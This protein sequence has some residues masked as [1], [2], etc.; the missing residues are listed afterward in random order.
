MQKCTQVASLYTKILAGVF[1]SSKYD[2]S[3]NG[4]VEAKGELKANVFGSKNSSYGHCQ[5]IHS[6]FWLEQ[7]ESHWLLF[8]LVQPLAFS[9]FW[10]RT[11][12]YSTIWLQSLPLL[13]NFQW[14]LQK[15]S[16]GLFFTFL[17]LQSCHIRSCCYLHGIISCGFFHQWKLEISLPHFH[18]TAC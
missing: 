10:A 11:L 6:L 14:G 7:K 13:A 16:N 3:C 12:S 5:I 18:C 2:A 15:T 9:N 4:S 1:G 17:D 8:Y